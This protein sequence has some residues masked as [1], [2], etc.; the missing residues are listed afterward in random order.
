VDREGDARAELDGLAPVL[1]GKNTGGFA[2]TLKIGRFRTA[3][4]SGDELP[5]DFGS[6]GRR[7]LTQ[8]RA[9]KLDAAVVPPG[10]GYIHAAPGG[11]AHEVLG[12]ASQSGQAAEGFDGARP[13]GFDQRHDLQAQAVAQELI[14]GV[15]FILAPGLANVPKIFAQR[16]PTDMQQGAE[17]GHAGELGAKRHGGEAIHARAP[18]NPHEHGFGLIVGVVGH[19]DAG[20][21][22]SAADDGESLKATLPRDVFTAAGGKR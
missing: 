22:S 14:G 12:F 8:G 2:E 19:D 3:S 7:N 16:G 13:E 1:A 10:G 6:D 20:T 15:G 4:K 18:E 9:R 11:G 5:E 21:S 17:D